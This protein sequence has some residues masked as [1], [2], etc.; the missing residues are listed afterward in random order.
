MKQYFFYL[1]LFSLILSQSK[2][3]QIDE[4]MKRFNAY[5]LFSGTVLVAEN[6]QIVYKNALGLANEELNVPHKTDMKFII[7]SMTKQFT[8]VLIMQMREQGKL[9]LDDPIIKHLPSYP[10]KRGNDITI[11]HLLSHSSGLHHYSGVDGFLL[12]KDRHQFSKDSIM[13]L[14]TV[15]DERNAPGERFRYSSIGY[16]LLGM[17]LEKVSGKPY[18]DLLQDNIFKPLNMINSSLDNGVDI[19]KNR[20]T[21][22]RY[23]F[24]K[25]RYDNAEYRDPSTTYST[26]GIISTVDDLLKWDQALYTDKLLTKESVK[27]LL[28]PKNKRYAYGFN[29]AIRGEHAKINARW[30][31]GLVTGYKSQITRLI[32]ENKTIILLTNRRDTDIDEITTKLISVLMDKEYSLPKRS[33]F[34]FILEKTAHESVDRAIKEAKTILAHKK[35]DYLTDEVQIAVAGLELKSDGAYMNAIKLMDFTLEAF[36]RTAYK[37]FLLF[38]IAQC[39]SELKN[40]TKMNEYAS[41]VLEI[42]KSHNGATELLKH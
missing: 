39:Y 27:L 5:G 3:D 33:L 35:D 37:T 17:V 8:A 41:L 21:P 34:K 20:A 9:S 12:N 1:L 30:H 16:Y 6:G 25:A 36:P 40:S 14:F 32:D 26:G 11:H 18:G 22:Y 28:E 7:G 42:D 19:L 29:I 38:K 10:S 15:L 24:L 2:S 13:N 23:N 31:G 4:V